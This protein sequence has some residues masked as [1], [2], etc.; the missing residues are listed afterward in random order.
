[1]LVLALHPLCDEVS[2]SFRKSATHEKYSNPRAMASTPG[3]CQSVPEAG[4]KRKVKASATTFRTP[5]KEEFH[6]GCVA[7]EQNVWLVRFFRLEFLRLQ[8]SKTD[9]TVKSPQTVPLMD[10][11]IR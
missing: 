3:H 9:H 10:R 5:E 8:I 6:V 11:C 2:L 1:M 4:L 7:L